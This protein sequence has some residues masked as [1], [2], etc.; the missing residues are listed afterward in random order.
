M[1]RPNII[2]LHI[3]QQNPAAIGAN[4]CTCASTPAMDSLYAQGVSFKHAVI[5]NPVCSPSRT[6]WYTGL[7][8][9]EHGQLSNNP[10]HADPSIPDIGPLITRGGYDSVFMGKWHLARPV[11]KSF[12]SRFHGHPHGE[13]GDAYVARAAEAFLAD[14]EEDK[15][16]FLN[17]GL[18]NPH[19]CCMW[20]YNFFP[21]PGKFELGPEMLDQLPALPPNHRASAS[22][23]I[24]KGDLI[25]PTRGHWTDTDWR[26]YMYS[27]FRQV[28][29]VDAEIGRIVG[30]LRNS[31]FA[32]NTLLIF[33]SDH[34]DGLA[35]HYHFGKEAPTDPSL[36]A[37]LICVL[38]GVQGRRDETH[39]ISSIDVTATICDYAGVDPLPGRRGVSLRPLIEGKA[40]SW[41]PYAPAAAN[42]G[43]VRPVRTTEHK[44]INDRK[45]N[46]YVLFDLAKDPGEMKNVVDDP[47][48]RPVL[49]QLKGYMDANE[50]TYHYA[51]QVLE[52]FKT[53]N[54][55]GGGV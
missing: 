22:P 1:S 49:A 19:D 20:G 9:E 38:P 44:L 42:R 2:F 14:R 31:R 4:G 18:L 5:A 45:T 15:P 7:M 50:S 10:P 32:D 21:G 24:L 55:G 39:A 6:S 48:Y 51:P 26:F 35:R 47:A 40:V 12:I 28:E 37:P 41:R 23:T 52:F 33:A 11:E 16:F 8:S 53:W 25:D 43:R 54:S 36:I 29:M 17:I 46:E 13:I 27:Y 34:G 30:A 3:D